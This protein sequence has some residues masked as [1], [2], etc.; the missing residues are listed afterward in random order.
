MD[1]EIKA[2]QAAIQKL[3]EEIR[4]LQNQIAQEKGKLRQ[5]LQGKNNELSNICNEILGDIGRI[6]SGKNEI[7]TS[8]QISND[9]SMKN[10]VNDLIKSNQNLETKASYL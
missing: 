1:E 3:T 2:A 10:A 6:L 8:M 7:L 9:I 5:I 4:E